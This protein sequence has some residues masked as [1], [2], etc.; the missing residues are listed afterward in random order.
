MTRRLLKAFVLY[1]LVLSS[2]YAVDRPLSTGEKYLEDFLE[3]TKTLEADFTQTLR[4]YNGEVLQQTSGKFFLK[5]PGKFRW[6]YVAP[7]EQ[8]IISDG[9][10]IWIYDVDLE[11]VTVQKQ[12]KG[13]GTT[14]MA[15]LQDS[16]QLHQQFEITPLDNKQG[17]YRLKLVSKD[18]DSDFG[19][20]VV[21]V[22]KNG[23]Q[24][25]QLHDQFEQV[26]DIIFEQLKT[27]TD[28]AAS[29]FKFKP[30]PGVDVFGGS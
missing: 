28:L 18:K 5:R 10:H 22:D 19:E 7:Y 3:N 17:I 26:T 24:F 21:G 30:P 29:L 14:P 12:S 8:K 9:K 2:A 4:A 6:D 16:L 27:N 15:L 23:L 20:I 11:Q 25:L 13:L 1:I